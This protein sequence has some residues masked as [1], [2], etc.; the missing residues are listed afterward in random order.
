MR[1]MLRKSVADEIC[2]YWG[3]PLVKAYNPRDP[4]FEYF[5]Q[6]IIAHLEKLERQER[7]ETKKSIAYLERLEKAQ[8]RTYN[9]GEI[10]TWKNGKFIKGPD[11]KWRRYY[12]GHSKQVETTITRLKGQ[13]RKC[14]NSSELWDLVFNNWGRFM[15]ADKMPLPI[16]REFHQYVSTIEDEINAGVAVENRTAHRAKRKRSGGA[17]RKP[18]IK[19]TIIYQQ[20]L[21][22]GTVIV[23]DSDYRYNV[24]G[25]N[26][27]YL[28]SEW[29]DSIGYQD[30]NGQLL[31]VEKNGQYNLFKDGK[32]LCNIWFDRIDTFYK[33]PFARVKLDN[34]FNYLRQDG[35][36]VLDEWL[37]EA[38]QFESGELDEKG[39]FNN[40]VRVS[41]N[42]KYNYL[43]KDGKLAFNDW[44]DD[45]EGD[46]GGV[47][48]SKD[49]KY[50]FLN[51]EGNLISKQWFASFSYFGGDGLAA[52]RNS[53][54]KANFIDLNG[55]LLCSGFDNIISGFDKNG[56]AR[57]YKDGKA[58]YL[59]KKGKFYRSN[60]LKTRKK[61]LDK[62]SQRIAEI[63]DG[64]NIP[65]ENTDN[66]A[67]NAVKDE[68]SG[69]TKSIDESMD[70]I[71][72][73]C[74]LKTDMEKLW[75]NFRDWAKATTWDGSYSTQATAAKKAKE[76]YEKYGIT[77]E[78][79][80]RQKKAV[81][82]KEIQRL[83]PQANTWWTGVKNNPPHEVTN[84]IGTI[85]KGNP[86]TFEQADSGNA[87]PD[88]GKS[89][90]FWTNCQSC[91]PVFLA[92]LLGFN[93]KARPKSGN[94]AAEELACH[95]NYAF[96]DQQTGTY[97]EYI[98]P[99]QQTEGDC[100]SWLNQNI[101]EG[102][103]YSI[104]FTWKKHKKGHILTIRKNSAGKLELYDPQSNKTTVDE[105]AIAKYLK[106]VKLGT[107]RLLN[108]T[109][110]VLN[111]SICEKVMKAVE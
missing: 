73:W 39:F 60:P 17:K 109:N 49:G 26:K 59:D 38:E 40:T 3:L 14:Q 97:P 57:V 29:F 35:S 48:V 31:Q 65:S 56:I 25:K 106:D 69:S 61:I 108:L 72:R 42:G 55:N 21:P 75:G 67:F 52:V 103:F 44:F 9:P 20:H 83:Q 91:V 90:G 111:E 8:R 50:N 34:K 104:E 62:T 66:P 101:E 1:V 100:V 82:Q 94:K 10:A 93:V 11:K 6:K 78:K 71:A 13:A 15:D 76:L 5:K 64:L 92:R 58:V 51:E 18:A 88:Y 85:T 87:N 63:F 32:Q 96:I 70:E 80:Y 45:V 53:A 54:W 110:C 22:N 16:V 102:E 68:Y 19:H 84:K 99:L 41:K 98:K 105:S 86:M 2:R 95:T 74:D 47:I 79:S 27:R 36:L 81:V 30:D 43:T 46:H 77:G 28:F 24:I 12:E 33:Q 23:V 37:N 89:R 4:K 107:V 7:A